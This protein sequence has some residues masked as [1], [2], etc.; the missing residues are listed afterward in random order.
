MRGSYEERA[1]PGESPVGTAGAPGEAERA[2][3]GAA[4][5]AAL[6]LSQQLGQV[7]PKPE[8]APDALAALAH[9]VPRLLRADL[10]SERPVFAQSAPDSESAAGDD[11]LPDPLRMVRP[12]MPHVWITLP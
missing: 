9:F 8:A 3:R 1:G 6:G 11:A 5:G 2:G 10:A 7:S 4:A 12:R